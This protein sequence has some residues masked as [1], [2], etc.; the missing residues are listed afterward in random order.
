MTTVTWTSVNTAF[1]TTDFAAIVMPPLRTTARYIAIFFGAHAA[2]DS[3]FRGLDMNG[4]A[5]WAAPRT[6]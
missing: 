6:R 4:N 2:Q 3:N 1:N 5:M